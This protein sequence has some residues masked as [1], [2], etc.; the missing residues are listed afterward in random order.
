MAEQ[1]VR[2]YTARLRGTDGCFGGNCTESGKDWEPDGD[3]VRA[4][5]QLMRERGKRKGKEV[6]NEAKK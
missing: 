4:L 5:M 6:M 3:A 1:R 2:A